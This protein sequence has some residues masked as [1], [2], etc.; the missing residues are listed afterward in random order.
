M[1]S[2]VAWIA[3]G[4]LIVFILGAIFAPLIVPYGQN[5]QNIIMR[6]KPPVW[7]EGG[8]R[9]HLLGTDELGRDLFTRIL[10]GSRSTI[11]VGVL[12]A[13]VSGGIGITLGLLSGYFRKLDMVIMRIADIQLAFPSMLLALAIIAV[14]GG[15]FTKLVIVLGITGWVQFSRVVRSEVLSIRTSEYIMAAQIVGVGSFR[16]LV[17]HI[18]PNIIA[19]A[20]TISTAQIAGAILSES[21]LSFLGLGIPPTTP[22]WGNILQS[23]QLY[24]GSAWWISLFP[25]LCITLIV[26]SISLMGDVLRDYMDPKTREN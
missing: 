26:L 23:G 24:M 2:W 19:P 12:T 15:G 8:S 9:E 20:V 25:G 10:Y 21:S 22:T 6:L 7:V 13:L 14:F 11:L 18:F 17:K 4:I 3:I 1:G 5:Q 16:I